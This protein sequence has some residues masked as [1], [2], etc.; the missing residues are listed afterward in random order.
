M[1]KRAGFENKDPL[2]DDDRTI[3]EEGHLALKAQLRCSTR[4]HLAPYGLEEIEVQHEEPRLDAA[5]ALYVT[6]TEYDQSDPVMPS[7]LSIDTPGDK[8]NLPVENKL[9]DALK[10]E[11]SEVI[12]KKKMDETLSEP[13][14]AMDI[15]AT[16]AEE[17]V[18]KR[19]YSPGTTRELLQD[20]SGEE[21][22]DTATPPLGYPQKNL[23]LQ[24][25]SKPA[26]MGMFFLN[27]DSKEKNI[28]DGKKTMLLNTLDQKG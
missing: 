24:P 26:D 12:E 14:E 22:A 19:N 21:W 1:L 23:E 20:L 11:R 17:I 3:V 2:Y 13:Q 10:K 7:N 16:P 15:G 5:G 6:L 4:R 27:N 18:R 28:F 25:G 8:R 9:E